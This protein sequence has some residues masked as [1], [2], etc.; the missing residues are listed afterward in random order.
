MKLNLIDI[1]NNL[2][3]EDYNLKKKLIKK[4]QK[5]QSGI[6]SVTVLTSGTPESGINQDRGVGRIDFEIFK[7]KLRCSVRLE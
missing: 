3:F 6:I 1:Y 2:G 5:S 4:I 7:T